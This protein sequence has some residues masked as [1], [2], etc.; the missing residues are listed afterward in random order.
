MSFPLGRVTD[1]QDRLKRDFTEFARLWSA[2]RE[3][4]RDDRCRQFEKQHL[5]SV[6]PSLNRLAA[7][8]REFCDAVRRA[9]SDLRDD[10]RASDELD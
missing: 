8:L 10:Q 9:D 3:D 6:G 2:V 5:S 1:C 4:W 7:E